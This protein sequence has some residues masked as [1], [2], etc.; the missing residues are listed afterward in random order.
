MRCSGSHLPRRRLHRRRS[1]RS[2]RP[3]HNSTGPANRR[4]RRT[5][6]SHSSRAHNSS[7]HRGRAR[8]SRVA[9][10]QVR[11]RLVGSMCGRSTRL[12]QLVRS[13]GAS[14]RYRLSQVS[15]GSRH[16]HSR[17]NRKPGNHNHLRDSRVLHSRG[18]CG[19]CSSRVSGPV[20]G[21]SR[22]PGLSLAGRSSVSRTH[23]KAVRRL[24]SSADRRVLSS[25]GRT[26][27]SRRGRRVLTK[28]VR[29][30]LSSVDRRV[31]RWRSPR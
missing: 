8:R 16:R 6:S 26:A 20:A 22:R 10:S 27:D 28:A 4:S 23:R 12:L 15:R 5:P 3:H 29:R 11:S 30:V 21:R 31:G 1:G 19:V 17:A 24:L 7:A 9:S 18:R 13:T 14:G 2:T 25:V